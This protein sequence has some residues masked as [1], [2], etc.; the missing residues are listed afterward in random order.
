MTAQD[1]G[2]AQGELSYF[3][4]Y[5]LEKIEEIDRSVRQ[6]SLSTIGSPKVMEHLK[7]SKREFLEAVVKVARMELE[8]LSREI[9]ADED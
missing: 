1:G 9:P 7:R 6:D 2:K 8:R 3:E 5:V 4:R